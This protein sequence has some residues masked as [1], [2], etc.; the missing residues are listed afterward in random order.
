[1]LL[2]TLIIRGALLHSEKTSNLFAQQ[3]QGLKT[4][5][6][7]SPNSPN[8]HVFKFMRKP[9]C[10]E[11]SQLNTGKVKGERVLKPATFLINGKMATLS[12]GLF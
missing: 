4:P 3:R 7:L 11:E 9:E 6:T 8:L 5:H 1:M 10:L 12:P 2:F